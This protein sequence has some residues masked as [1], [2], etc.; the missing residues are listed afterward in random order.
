MIRGAYSRLLRMNDMSGTAYL[1]DMDGVI[2]D[3]CAYHVK[4]WL[5]IAERHGGRL[6]EEQ[7]VAW[8]GA[9]GRDYLARM[10]D[11]MPPPERVEELLREKEAT[12]RELYRPDLVA[13]KGL[14]DFL[15]RARQRGIPC[16]IVTGGTM[17]NVDFVLDGTGLRDYFSCI[18]DSSCYER[19]K[20]APDCYLQG[21]ARLGVEPR[22]CVVF[23]DAVN[24][25]E[26][27]IAAGMRSVAITGTNTRETLVAAGAGL[28]VDSFEEVVSG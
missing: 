19:G 10:F 13:R 21:A 8:M 1:F 5:K 26:S 6:T 11:A 9:P 23:E 16:A 22:D 28:V 2:V 15:E 14:A 20:P 27:A 25:I 17:N 3:N 12:Y 24:G 4:S 7:I 18:V